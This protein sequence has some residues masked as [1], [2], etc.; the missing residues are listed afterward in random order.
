[1]ID[2]GW[3]DYDVELRPDPW[4]RVELK[5]ADEEHEGARLKNHVVARVRLSRQSKIGLA[6]GLAGAVAA[7]VIGL[8]A[9]SLGLGALTA[10]GTTSAILAMVGSGRF[11]Y[12]AVEECAAELNLTPLGKP[13][14][15]AQLA[16]ASASPADRKT[17][18][19]APGLSASNQP[20]AE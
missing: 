1:V 10:A 3:N 2:P 8:P 17:V 5:T 14:R 9:L 11:A 6:A 7:A 4:T 15:A 19:A 12:R 18:A 16:S 20:A 13:T